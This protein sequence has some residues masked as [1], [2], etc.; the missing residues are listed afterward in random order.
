MGTPFLA[1]LIVLAIAIV[2]LVVTLVMHLKR[3][4][5]Q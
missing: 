1:I 5:Q 4:K 2:A 3:R